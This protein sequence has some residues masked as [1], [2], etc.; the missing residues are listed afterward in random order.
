M[1][2]AAITCNQS[3]LLITMREVYWLGP[4]TGN[5]VFDYCI[6]RNFRGPK[7]SQISQNLGANHINFFLFMYKLYKNAKFAKFNALKNFYLYGIAETSTLRHEDYKY[8]GTLMVKPN[9]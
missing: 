1:D 3:I 4:S 9:E 8:Q 2:A 6:N 7:I 5:C